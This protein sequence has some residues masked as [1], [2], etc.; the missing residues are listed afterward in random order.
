MAMVTGLLSAGVP[1]TGRAADTNAPDFQEVY[2]LLRAHLPGATDAGLNEAAVTGLLAQLKGR[3]SLSGDSAAPATN[4]IV[5]RPALL[6]DPSVSYL[7]VV[8]VTEALAA[9]INKVM[10]QGFAMA[11][12]D[13]L[14]PPP[15][16]TNRLSGGS[17]GTLTGTVVDL[18]FASGDAYT[19]VGAV[20]TELTV[21]K[22]PLLVLINGETSGAAEVLAAKLRAAGALLIGNPTAGLAM[23]TED[24]PLANGQRLRVGT[25]PIKLN[26]VEMAALTPDIPVPAGLAEERA[27]MENPYGP[28]TPAGGTPGTGTNSFIPL[29]DHTTEADLVRQKRKDGEGPVAVNPGPAARAEA[30]PP[31][32]RDAVLVRALDLTRALAVL[33]TPGR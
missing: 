7:R 1:A 27:W 14:L 6:A 24:F 19:S 12:N 5:V 15:A 30:A 3:A 23:M 22:L 13:P 32:L 20:V 16:W 29:L 2:R 25:T 9:Q 17:F 18:R 11:D 8:R 28:A 21:Q 33:K 26:G 10:T 4:V 31:V